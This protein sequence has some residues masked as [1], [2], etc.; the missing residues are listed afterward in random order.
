MTGLPG[1]LVYA[2]MCPRNAEAAPVCKREGGYCYIQRIAH[3]HSSIPDDSSQGALD[4][5]RALQ[6]VG[7]PPYITPVPSPL[8]ASP[9]API[10]PD[11]SECYAGNVI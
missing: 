6:D 1:R 3:V 11:R 2:I 4:S 10:D 5:D 9:L 8:P 7:A